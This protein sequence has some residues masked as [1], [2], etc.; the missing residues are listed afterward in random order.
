MREVVNARDDVPRGGVAWRQPSR[1]FPPWRTI[2]GWFIRLGD[3]GTWESIH[4]LVTL[5]RERA[6]REASPSAVI[7]D[8]QS[9]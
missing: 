7:I 3:A 5:D 1:C 2:Y 8:G 4:R 6:E 9:V